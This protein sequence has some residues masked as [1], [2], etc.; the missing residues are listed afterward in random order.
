MPVVG[1]AQ[2]MPGAFEGEFE[3]GL[4]E[5]RVPYRVV[6]NS[7]LDDAIVVLNAPGLP[8]LYDPYPSHPLM[9]VRRYMP[10]RLLPGSP[11]WKVDVFYRTPQHKPGTDHARGGGTGTET[12]GEFTNPI[13]ELP[14]V[15]FH[16]TSREVLLTQM[17]DISTGTVKPPTSSNGEAYDPPPKVPQRYLTLEIAR[18]EPIDAPHP[19]LAV[20]Y[21]NAVNSDVFWGLPPGTWMVKNISPERQTRVLQGGTTALFLRVVYQLE[22]AASWDIQL[23]DFGTYYLAP[24]PS[25]Q[26]VAQTRK[27]KFGTADGHPT[28]GLLNGQGGRLPDSTSFTADALSRITVPLAAAVPG[29]IV[30]N[31]IYVTNLAVTLTNAGGN[32]PAPLRQ[33]TVY[34]AVVVESTGIRFRLASGP[35]VIVSTQNGVLTLGGSAVTGLVTSVL[36]AGMGVIGPGVP[37]GTTILSID[38]PTQIHLTANATVGGA[39]SLQFTTGGTPIPLQDQGSGT[40]F[41]QPLGVFRPIRPSNWLPFGPL[42]LPQSFLEVQ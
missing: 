37:V 14:T 18:N 21:M 39:Q 4:Y 32:L 23:L 35:V 20:Q 29:A 40:S 36:Q 30:Q 1:S 41:I 24:I 38:S 34:Y 19:A 3:V 5:V 15:K 26:N 42:G 28:T 16:V 31:A 10:R 33:N 12:A 2:I 27:L 9:R 6:T 11:V 13:L 7:L 8:L 22:A 17:Y 25:L